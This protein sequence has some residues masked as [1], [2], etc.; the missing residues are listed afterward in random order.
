[1]K[2]T[3]TNPF[4]RRPPPDAPPRRLFRKRVLAGG[5]AL[6]T[7]GVGVPYAW[8]SL[9]E[10]TQF[11]GTLHNDVTALKVDQARLQGQVTQVQKDLDLL[12]RHQLRDVAQSSPTMQPSEPGKDGTP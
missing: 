2:P 3:R 1:M 5:L 4:T 10:A 7:S 9:R 6:V 12:L 11:F 8:Q